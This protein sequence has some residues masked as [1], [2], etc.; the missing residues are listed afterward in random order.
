MANGFTQPVAEATIPSPAPAP[1]RSHDWT[2]AYAGLGLGYAF[3]GHDR[4]ALNPSPPGPGVIGTLV[5]SGALGGVQAG[6]NWQRG[7]MV[8][9]IEGDVTAGAISSGFTA[10][11]DS[12]SMDIRAAVSLRARAGIARDTNLFYVTGGV[13]AAHVG[14][15]AVGGG[16]NIASDFIQGGYALGAGWERALQNGWSVRGEYIYS[17]YGSRDLTDAGLTTRATPDYHAVR[18]GLNRRF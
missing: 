14:Y 16:A 7:D 10:G 15:T 5:N 4:V 17:N 13:A 6:M 1:A 11:V 2:G 9:G 3:G 12:A 8:Y 18:V